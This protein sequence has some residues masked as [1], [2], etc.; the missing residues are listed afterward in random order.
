[1]KKTRKEV[2]QDEIISSLRK[3]IQSLKDEK[4]ILETKY[5]VLREYIGL[6]LEKEHKCNIIEFKPKISI[7]K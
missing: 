5:K 2:E 1:M 7:N 6:P 4:L 3:E